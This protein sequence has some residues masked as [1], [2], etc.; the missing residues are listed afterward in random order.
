[1]TEAEIVANAES[2]PDNPPSDPEWLERAGRLIPPRRKPLIS[3][4]LDPDVVDWFRA[5]GP[6]YQTRMNS[7]L[8]AYVEHE[9]GKARKAR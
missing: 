5:T 8:R 7:V 9:R 1:M 4:R 3:L 6:G 2:D